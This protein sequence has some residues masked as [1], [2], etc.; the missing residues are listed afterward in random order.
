MTIPKSVLAELVLEVQHIKPQIYFKSSLTALS[1][2][3]EDQV[4]ASS[5]QPLVIATFQREHFYRQEAHRYRRIANLTS[6]VY[7][8]A[9]P[10]TEF[11]NSS[12]YYETVAFNSKDA[13]SREWNLLVLG[14]QYSSCLICNECDNSGLVDE[15]SQFNGMEQARRFEG[16][17]TFDHQVCVQSAILLFHRILKYRPELKKKVQLATEVYGINLDLKKGKKSPKK[18]SPSNGKNKQTSAVIGNTNFHDPFAQRL[19]TYLQASQYKLIK[20]YRSIA[21]QEQKQRLINI[22]SSSMRRSLDPDEIIKVAVAELGKA[23]LADR[24]LIY[25]CRPTDEIA[26]I[27]HEYLRPS[28][29]SLL[30]QLWPLKE[31][32]LFQK[33]IQ[34]KERVYIEDTILLPEDLLAKTSETTKSQ[35][36]NSIEN[37]ISQWEISSWLIMPLLYQGRLLGIVEL[38]NCGSCSHNWSEE[39]TDLVEAI[40]TQLSMTLIQAE[41][42]TH[43]EELNQQLEALD[44]TRSNLIA[45]TGHELRTPLSTIQVCLESLSQEPDMPEELRQVMLETALADADRMRN[46]VQDFLTLSHLESGR[47]EWNIEH[48]PLLECVDLAL[49]SVRAHNL[50]KELP[51]ITTQVSSELPLVLADGEWLVEVLSKLLDNACKFTQAEGKV[52]ITATSSNSEN[53]LEVTISDTGRGI[54]PARLEAVFDRFYQEEGALRRSVGGTGLGLAICRQV[55]T[56]LGGKIWAESAGKDRGSQFHFTIPIV[57]NSQKQQ[58]M[59]K[60]LN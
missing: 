1:H 26:T 37:L 39:Q 27:T 45:I 53:M 9:A 48:L 43:L 24:C 2:A 35:G 60:K 52:I 50:E 55:I 15:T 13:L 23:L 59:Q 16:I 44:R 28:V 18:K 40:A 46:L 51:N 21:A 36:R 42:Y 25:Q 30:N 4:L 17:W 7:V 3:M 57:G 33:V 19:V 54:E 5:D 47:V 11:K 38:H 20:A 29:K 31:N 41:T 6:Q 12:E 14:Q 8:L 58:E 49:S 10:E 56:R 34:T 22:I 32:P